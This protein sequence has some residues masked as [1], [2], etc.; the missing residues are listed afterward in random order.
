M[1]VNF[2]DSFFES[3][4]TLRRH[5]T[6]WYKTYSLFRNDIPNF[7]KNIWMF[8]ILLWQH[9]WWDYRF[10]LLALRTSLEIME[11][12]MHNGSE[13]RED[14]D[15]KIS[16]MQRAIEIL[17]NF[18]KD[19]FLELAEKELGFEYQ[20]KLEFE[21]VPGESELFQIKKQ[22]PEIE[23]RNRKISSTSRS[24]EEGQWKELWKI[25]EG[26]DY[27]KFKKEENWSDQF[28]GSGLRGWWD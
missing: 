11:K 8:R 21:E 2:A 19:N 22:S 28:D 24:I 4:E 20:A 7:F 1:K 13:I 16:K 9:R 5:N 15:K 10:H 12:D 14:R 3:L 25:L 23:K 27:K 6:W 26:Q 18:E 17:Q